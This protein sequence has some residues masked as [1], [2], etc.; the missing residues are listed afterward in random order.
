[1]DPLYPKWFTEK[2]KFDWERSYWSFLY[3]DRNSY[4]A[5]ESYRLLV[6]LL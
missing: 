6:C 2:E 5:A 1:M 4:I 3:T